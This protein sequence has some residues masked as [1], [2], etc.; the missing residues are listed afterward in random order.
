VAAVS[1]LLTE[2]RLHKARPQPID[3]GALARYDRPLS[4]LADYGASP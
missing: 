4:N 3:V 1:Y 2:A